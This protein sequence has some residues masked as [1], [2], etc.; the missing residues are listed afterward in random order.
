MATFDN[1]KPHLITSTLYK[2]TAITAPKLP[3]IETSSIPFLSGIIDFFK[4]N[5]KYIII[6][7]IS[8]AIFFYKYNEAEQ[9]KK[10]KQIEKKIMMENLKNKIAEQ[11]KMFNQNQLRIQQM[12]NTINF[13]EANQYYGDN[14]LSNMN[15]NKISD[16]SM[17]P[18]NIPPENFNNTNDR[19]SMASRSSSSKY[20]TQRTVI[21]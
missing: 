19:N 17:N 2:N 11:D 18:V 4:E 13:N 10:Q 7:L 20:Q 3:V 5:Y 12:D 8:C 21:I 14:I 6:L 9:I 16:Y 1:S 15:M